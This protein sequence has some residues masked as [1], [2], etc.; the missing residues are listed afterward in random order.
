MK[1]LDNIA[2]LVNEGYAPYKLIVERL[3]K[4]EF[5]RWWDTFGPYIQHRREIK[6]G[7]SMPGIRETW[8]KM[9]YCH[10]LQT[11]VAKIEGTNRNKIKPVETAPI[12]APA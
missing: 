3:L 8:L 12:F 11:L 1:V 6:K 10:H 4:N 2:C 9:E 5:L 7:P